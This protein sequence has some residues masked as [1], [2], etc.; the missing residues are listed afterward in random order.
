MEH[1]H[2]KL[3]VI[4]YI[5][6]A[7]LVM[8]I[9]FKFID[10]FSRLSPITDVGDSEQISRATEEIKYIVTDPNFY[11]FNIDKESVQNIKK[12]ATSTV[13]IFDKDGIT[14]KAYIVGDIE[15][16]VVLL[17]KMEKTALPVASMSK[18]VTAL[19]SKELIQP[20]KVITI[21]REE[22]GLPKDG[23]MIIADEQFSV[24]E[25]LYPLLLNS[26]NVAAEALASATGRVGFLENMSS[27]AWELGMSKTY[28]A[29]ASG[30]SPKNKASAEDLFSLAKYLYV[31]RP[32]ILEITRVSKTEVSTT[33]EPNHG[34][35]VFTSTHPFIHEKGFIGGKTG[36][37]F[38][39]GETM[40]TIL[41]I[42]GRKFVFIV[43]GSQYGY[44]EKD[45][46]LLIAKLNKQI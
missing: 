8:V 11:S 31:Y 43:L 12:I 39:A 30:L 20:D 15:R 16:D 13:E 19:V 32:D 18:L 2:R 40:M 45:T 26:S 37:T 33:T 5:C 29:D 7:I 41:D 42:K 14:A 28:F 4:T 25:L 46:R 21:T 23:S 22:A 3:L 38:E 24:S 34:S 35:H 10:L 44:R 27:Y 17:K 1:E 6:S 9:T 36:R